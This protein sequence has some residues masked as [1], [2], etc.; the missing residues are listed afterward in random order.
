VTCASGTR[1]YERPPQFVRRGGHVVDVVPRQMVR[2]CARHRRDGDVEIVGRRQP[3]RCGFRFNSPPP[4]G[5]L[6]LEG[7]QRK[8]KR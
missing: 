5:V 1:W 3:G 2:A 4:G 7:P 6:I 8:A